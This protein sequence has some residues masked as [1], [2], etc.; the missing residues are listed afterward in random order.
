[1]TDIFSPQSKAGT[2]EQGLTSLPVNTAML[3]Q[4]AEH[5]RMQH[6]AAEL[7]CLVCQ[8]QT[9]AD[10]NSG[11]AIDL[12]QQITEQIRA[13]KSDTAIKQYMVDRYGEFV[14]Y[15]PPFNAS[16]A[17][18][19]LGPFL[20]LLIGIWLTLRIIKKNARKAETASATMTQPAVS[21]EQVNALEQ[22]YQNDIHHSS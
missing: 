16:N 7:R 22:R 18:L 5:E 8:N 4:Q 10:S 6:L 17:A 1:M 20:L 21:P 12:R 9:I 2:A 11:L 14:L 15:K 13:G 19:W 3:S